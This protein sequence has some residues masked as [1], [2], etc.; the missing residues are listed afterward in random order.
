MAGATPSSRSPEAGV[1]VGRARRQ[2]NSLRTIAKDIDEEA[3]QLKALRG[4]GFRAAPPGGII[5]EK[6]PDNA[7]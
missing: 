1:V 6:R 3:G 4:E 5:R 2:R 7:A